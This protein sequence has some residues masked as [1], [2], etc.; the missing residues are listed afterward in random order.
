MIDRK[1]GRVDCAII[2]IIALQYKDVRN[3]EIVILML[4][5]PAVDV[6]KGATLS[7]PLINIA[8]TLVAKELYM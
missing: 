7:C 5:L 1:G 8:A 2:R 4:S 6:L 3:C